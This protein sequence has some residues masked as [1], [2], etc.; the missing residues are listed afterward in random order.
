MEKKKGIDKI[1]KALSDKYKK[2][3]IDGIKQ[4]MSD[5]VN[6]FNCEPE[7]RLQVFEKNNIKFK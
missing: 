3:K 4:A 1:N 6:L 2:G 7:I 5:A